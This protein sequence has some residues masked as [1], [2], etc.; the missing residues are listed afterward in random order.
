MRR[1]RLGAAVTQASEHYYRKNYFLRAMQR[2]A[3]AESRFNYNPH[4]NLA[5]D[6]AILACWNELNLSQLA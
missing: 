4:Q 1:C 6:Q 5:S 3:G 2:L